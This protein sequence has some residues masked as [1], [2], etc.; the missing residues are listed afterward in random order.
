MLSITVFLD[1]AQHGTHAEAASPNSTSMLPTQAHL[2]SCGDWMKL[3]T[4]GPGAF[5]KAGGPRQLSIL[6]THIS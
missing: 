1:L 3:Q 4:R 6:C 2:P 5:G